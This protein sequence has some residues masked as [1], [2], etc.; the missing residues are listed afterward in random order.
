MPVL[1]N[2]RQK[3]NKGKGR[4][5]NKGRHKGRARDKMSDVVEQETSAIDII[6]EGDIEKRDGGRVATPHKAG[7]TQGGRETSNADK[8]KETKNNLLALY[9][10]RDGLLLRALMYDRASSVTNISN[11]SRRG[12]GF[13]LPKG[14]FFC[15]MNPWNNAVA[16]CAIPEDVDYDVMKNLGPDSCI[17]AVDKYVLALKGVGGGAGGGETKKTFCQI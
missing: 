2:K 14:K 13:S 8:P 10:H 15:A 4:R 17:R 5:K 12:L 1:N 7:G 3:G 9:D 11:S 6:S 16:S